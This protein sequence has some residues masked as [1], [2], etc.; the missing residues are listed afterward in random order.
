MRRPAFGA[1]LLA[2]LGL[3]TATELALGTLVYRRLREALEADLGRRLVHVSQLLATGVDAPLVDQ[4]RDGDEALAAYGIV[5][6]RLAAQ[7][8]AAGVERAYVFDRA[9]AT[10]LD[11]GPK[12]PGSA[13]YALL[14]NRLEVESAAAGRAAATRLYR[15]EDGSLRL[16]AFAPVVREGGVG[17]LVG[18]DASPDFFASLAALRRQMLLLGGASL[19]VA[20][21]AAMLIVRQVGERLGRVRRAVSRATRGDLTARAEVAGADEIGALGRDLDAMIATMVDARDH[22]AAV[23]GSLEAALLATDTS[24]VVTVA[25]ASARR[26]LGR[27]DLLGRPLTEVCADEPALGAFVRVALAGGQTA[28]AEV[29]LGGGLP[30]G[31]RVVAASASPLVRSGERAGLALSLLDVTELRLLERRARSNERL[32]ALGGMAGGLLHEIRN[33]LASMMVYL[34]LLRA[35]LAGEAEP[36]EVLDRAI[37]DGERLARFLEDFQIFAGLRPLRLETVDLPRAA[38]AVAAA[39]AW[40]PAVACSVQGEDGVALVA[41]RRL[42]EHALR[43]LLRNALEA[44]TERGGRVDVVVAREEGVVVVGV[45]DDGPGIPAEEVERILDPLFTTKSRGTGLGL[46]IVQR[47][48]ELHGGTLRVE[49]PA[50]GG[51][52]FRLRFPAPS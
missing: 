34:D 49:S 50:G 32:A 36:R 8:R 24:G 23:L 1:L 26:L 3:L 27:D 13:L 11:T 21:L 17:L 46:S 47:V 37:A 40:P 45:T 38:R 2:I 52:S 41:D 12:A 5:R 4:F 43:N 19:A 10:R 29:A 30:A 20:G 7:A 44:L 18:V 28:G 51:A 9:L 35:P 39:L 6:E 22:F 42:L 33:P 15:G 25:N 31:G 16:S 14:A 48:L